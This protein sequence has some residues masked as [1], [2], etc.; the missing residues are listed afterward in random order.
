VD[1]RQPI[2]THVFGT[3]CG[4]GS[5]QVAGR[6]HGGVVRT[7]RRIT[8]T[9]SRPPAIPTPIIH[10]WSLPATVH[11][12]PSVRRPALS[13]HHVIVDTIILIVTDLSTHMR[14]FTVIYKSYSETEFLVCTSKLQ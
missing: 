12:Q 13:L 8:S 2:P 3:Q 14:L 11:A 7:R 5:S 6:E 1:A 9:L 4:G 10:A